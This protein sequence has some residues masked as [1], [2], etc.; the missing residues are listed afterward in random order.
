LKL[1]EHV[2]FLGHL[3]QPAP[4]IAVADA[5]CL[6][7][8]F[9]GFPNVMLEAMALGTPVIA[10]DIAVVR[11][12]GRISPNGKDRGRDYVAMF[13]SQD[14]IE[15]A[16]KIRRLRLNPTATYSRMIAARNL[17]R[18]ALAIEIIMPRL[19]AI[20]LQAHQNRQRM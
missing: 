19:E 12:L 8:T 6:P 1:S 17:T 20:M 7:S 4:W 14:A 3:D 9:E 16:Q 10:S 13:K 5:L 2:E 11:S 18:R 15:L